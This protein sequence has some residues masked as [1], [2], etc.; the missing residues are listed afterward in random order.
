MAI[1]ADDLWKAMR[2]TLGV[3]GTQRYLPD[4]QVLPSINGGL[5]QFNAYV[6]SLFAERKGSEELLEEITMMRVFQTNAMSGVVLKEAQLG[7]KVW[8]INAVYP[9]PVTKPENPQILPSQEDE[10]QWR[11]DL[12]LRRPGKYRAPRKTLEE[13]PDTE[14]SRLVAG[15]E[16]MAGTP[17][18][19]FAYYL[20]GNRTADGWIPDGVE[21]LVLPESANRKTLVGVSYM[22]GVDPVTSF[23]DVIPYPPS[24]FQLI[25]DLALNE[26]SVR[27]GAL[28]LY[29]VTQDSV[30]QL[31]QTQS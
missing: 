21:L 15:S 17:L 4:Q 11:S 30:R 22:K 9:R 12:T 3:A 5:R 31:L 13:I 27:Q 19:S 18:M 1:L 23:S 8:S 24:A 26:L 20:P 10:S 2:A 25:R 14:M 16:K 6:G 29:K 7:H 28:P